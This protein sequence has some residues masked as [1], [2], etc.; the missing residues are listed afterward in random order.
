MP[1]ISRQST[2]Y[3]GVILRKWRGG[4]AATFLPDRLLSV[5]RTHLKNV[6]PE[7]LNLDEKPIFLKEDNRQFQQVDDAHLQKWI[8]KAM[9]D[10][11]IKWNAIFTLYWRKAPL[12]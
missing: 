3:L 2:L 12:F 7:N 8:K 1:P 4:N 6:K 5:A 11:R 9:Q 10:L